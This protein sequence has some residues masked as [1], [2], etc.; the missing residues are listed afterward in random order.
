[1]SNLNIKEQVEKYGFCELYEPDMIELLQLDK[2]KLL[3]TEERNRD[4]GKL[5]LSE[6]LNFAANVA[7]QYIK[8]TYVDPYWKDSQFLKYTIWDGVDRDNQG[9][10]T[11]M[12]EEYDIFFLFYNDDTS[13]K[14]GGAIQFKYKENDVF[15]EKSFQPK[16]GSLFCVSNSRGFWHRAESTSIKR[17]VASF[18]FIT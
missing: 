14:T 11:D 1:M 5:D 9:W 17:R 15:V 16:A 8:N 12:F 6:D 4:N 2:Y 18:D 10:H 13:K 3:N 7:S